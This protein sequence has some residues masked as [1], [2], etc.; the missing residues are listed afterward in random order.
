LIEFLDGE[1]EPLFRHAELL[2]WREFRLGEI[3]SSASCLFP[4]PEKKTFVTNEKGDPLG[5]AGPSSF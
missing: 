2:R 3:L 5:C 4:L 1:G